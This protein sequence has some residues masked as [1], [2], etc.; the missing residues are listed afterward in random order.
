MRQLSL[1]KAKKLGLARVLLAASTI[2]GTGP[3]LP[4]CVLQFARSLE[5]MRKGV[6]DPLL[7]IP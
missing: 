5:L 2:L 4:A 6:I 1:R 3:A 7:P